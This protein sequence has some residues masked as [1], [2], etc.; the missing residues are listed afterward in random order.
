M[1]PDAGTRL[2]LY[3]FFTALDLRHHK[4]FHCMELYR[5]IL[6]NQAKECDTARTGPL[7]ARILAGHLA[8]FSPRTPINLIWKRRNESACL[9]GTRKEILGGLSEARDQGID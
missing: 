4:K 3:G 7:E 1:A 6:Y 9:F 2:M 8:R 5:R